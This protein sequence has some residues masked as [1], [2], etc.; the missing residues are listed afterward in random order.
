[1]N[2]ALGNICQGTHAEHGNGQGLGISHVRFAVV[3]CDHFFCHFVCFFYQQLSN[4]HVSKKFRLVST[5]FFVIVNITRLK[6]IA[7]C[8]YSKNV[9][10]LLGY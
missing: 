8:C 1:M 4:Q 6:K 3:C 9:F 10:I 2:R 7:E 5:G